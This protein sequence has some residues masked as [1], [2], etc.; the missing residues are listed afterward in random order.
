MAVIKAS[1]KAL[2]GD[3]ATYTSIEGSIGSLTSQRDTL[4]G[5]IKA[6]LSAAAFDGTAISQSQAQSWIDQA[7]QLIGQAQGL[8]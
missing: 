8:S 4:A 5:Q 7:N 3:D 1:T 2:E 6:A